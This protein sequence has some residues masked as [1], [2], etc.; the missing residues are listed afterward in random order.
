MQS[1]LQNVKTNVSNARIKRPKVIKSLKSK[2][3]FIASPPFYVEWRPSHPVT[4]LFLF[5]ILART[6]NSCNAKEDAFIRPH[7]YFLSGKLPSLSKRFRIISYSPVLAKPEII[8]PSTT[9][10]LTPAC[11]LIRMLIRHPPDSAA[12]GMYLFGNQS[13]AVFSA[14]PRDRK[15]VG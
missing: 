11:R 9:S 14:K 13:N 7:F 3:F 8:P 1:Y 15:S 4:R 2:W 12:S 6:G 5:S 10:A